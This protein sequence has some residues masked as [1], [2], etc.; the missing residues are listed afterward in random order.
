[1]CGVG[2]KYSAW[3]DMWLLTP[4]KHTTYIDDADEETQNRWPRQSTPYIDDGDEEIQNWWPQRSTQHI[5]MTRTEKHKTG[6]PN[7]AY[8]IY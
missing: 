5:L 1:M 8:H 7:E 2:V 3:C 4:T 6:D